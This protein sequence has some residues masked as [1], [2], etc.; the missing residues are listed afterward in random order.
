MWGHV[1]ASHAPMESFT[2]LVGRLEGERYAKFHAEPHFGRKH[3]VG[4]M[5]PNAKEH[6]VKTWRV[7][8]SV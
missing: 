6:V 4:Q 1:L 7:E 2:C 5:S 8:M 3:F